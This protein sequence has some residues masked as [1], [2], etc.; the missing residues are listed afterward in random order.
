MRFPIMNASLARKTLYHWF[1]TVFS[2]EIAGSQATK[3]C[4]RQLGRYLASVYEPQ[5]QDDS[6]ILQPR[7]LSQSRVKGTEVKH[8]E[9]Y[10]Y[11]YQ[12]RYHNATIHD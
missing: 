4:S 11:W 10:T 9:T 5:R 3:R 1:L 2:G 7:V 6:R 12:S 8:T